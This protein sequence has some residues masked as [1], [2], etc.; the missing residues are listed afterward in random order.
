M[1]AFLVANISSRL[2]GFHKKYG[3][4]LDAVGGEHKINRE[5]FLELSD[6]AVAAGAWSR[7]GW[8]AERNPHNK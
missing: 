5:R 4:K 8:Q 1:Q 6:R 7:N 2:I 3:L